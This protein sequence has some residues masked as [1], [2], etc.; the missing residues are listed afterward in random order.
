VA[1]A[2]H[3]QKRIAAQD[4][5]TSC[6]GVGTVLWARSAICGACGMLRGLLL[7]NAQFGGCWLWPGN[8]GS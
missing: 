8:Y 3:E 2:A 1:Y 4:G 5:A 7:S 6:L